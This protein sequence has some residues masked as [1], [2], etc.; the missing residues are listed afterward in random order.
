MNA[1][2]SEEVQYLG[3]VLD[4]KLVWKKLVEIMSCAGGPLPRPGAQTLCSNA[5]L[6]SLGRCLFMHP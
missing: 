1:L 6:L 5:C 4:K 2:L 3:V